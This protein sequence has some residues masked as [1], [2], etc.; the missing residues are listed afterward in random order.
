[1]VLT[2]HRQNYSLCDLSDLSLK[3]I[4]EDD[5]MS[6]FSSAS[7]SGE[8]ESNG[9]EEPPHAGP[10]DSSSHLSEEPCQCSICL[11]V[12]TDPVTTPCGHVFCKTCLSNYWDNNLHCPLCKEEFTERPELKINTTLTEAVGHLQKENGLDQP[13]IVCDVC[14]EVKLKALKSCLDCGVTFCK[15]HLESHAVAKLKKH[16]LINPVKKLEDYICQKHERPLLFFCRDEQTYVCQFCTETDHRT[17]NTVPVEE[18][19]GEKK[20]QLGKMHTEVQQMIQYRT[21][22]IEEI[23]FS[24]ELR[25]KNTE[26]EI[27][28][29]VEVFTA[30]MRSIERTRDEL[31]EAMEEKQ[32][33]VEKSA[34]DIIKALEQEIN[35]LKEKDTELEQ[36][37]YT[38][39]H[40]HLLQV[41][42][43]LRSPE[44][45]NNWADVRVDTRVSM[46]PV[47]KALLQLQQTLN[48]TLFDSELKRMEQYAV[49]VTLDPDTAHP[50]LILSNDGK[51]VVCGDKRHN[52]PDNP[53]RFT[54]YIMVLGK[55][56]FSSGR[57][58]YEVEVKGKTEW[59]FG[60]AKA[61]INRKGM[62]TLRPEHGFWAL[63]LTN[64]N[65]YKP[66]TGPSVSLLL[67]Q[68]PQKVGVFVD[69]E[70]GLVSFYD[71]QTKSRIYSFTGQSFTEK[72]YPYF[73]PGVNDKNNLA[74]LIIST[75]SKSE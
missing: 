67:R 3:R 54:Y 18:E 51:Q 69:Y 59:N 40:L 36:L 38:E 42:S 14:T 60:V 62:I 37:S 39:D 75:I 17:H 71:V 25:K 19:S 55:E 68:K 6:E 7:S 16:M 53:K 22:K 44:D 41:Y 73:C 1:A 31:H 70:E 47:R 45:K 56:G 66:G 4:Q 33:A 24:V 15:S 50:T 43:S 63:I 65:E 9:M 13:E 8:V 64:K 46:E 57:F 48:K 12:F 10:H 26:K 61:S 28:D 2:L 5:K 29:S 11:N 52:L 32:R 20:T 34:E 21:K 74:P 35:E 30:L 58:Y 23:K 27:A 49:D 72:L